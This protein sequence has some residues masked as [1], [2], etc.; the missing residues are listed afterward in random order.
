LRQ[1]NAKA[2]I[3]AENLMTMWQIF[4]NSPDFEPKSFEK[5]Q[6]KDEMTRIDN[7]LK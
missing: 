1:G 2:L 5:S 4:V 7:I 3:D 6:V